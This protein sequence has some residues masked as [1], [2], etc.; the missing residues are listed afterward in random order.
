[1]T[2][3]ERQQLLLNLACH[4]R[5]GRLE[6]LDGSDLLDSPQLLNGEVGDAD[7]ANETLLSQ[8]AAFRCEMTPRKCAPPKP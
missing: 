2:G 8:F 7:M 3:G 1:M 6:R 4:Q 5:V